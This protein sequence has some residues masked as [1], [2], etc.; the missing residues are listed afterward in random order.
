VSAD[1]T[2]G[3]GGPF[4]VVTAATISAITPASGA[5]GT[6]VTI[7]G[8]GFGASQGTSTVSFNGVAASVTNWSDTSI[9]VSV[10]SGATTGNVVVTVA[11]VSSKP[12]NFVVAG[13]LPTGSLNTARN[14]Q[15]ATLLDNGMVLI[16][17]GFDGNF[18]VL[19]NT[20]LYDPSSGKFS[21]TGSLTTPRI[22][23]TATL[24]NNGMVLMAGGLDG[25]FNTLSST[26]LYD[27]AERLFSPAGSLNTAR[28]S[29]LAVTLKNGM[30]LIVGGLDSNFN[31]LSSAELYDPGSGSFTTVAG[32]LGTARSQ[33][34]ATLLNDGTVLI[35]GGFDGNNNP[36]ASA[37]LYDPATGTFR[38][39]GT[40]NNARGAHTATL[41][42]NGL[43]LIAGGNDSNSNPIASAELYDPVA[44]SFS[45]TGSPLVPRAANTATLLNNGM[46]LIAGG[47][48]SNFNTI[49]SA[50][51]YDPAT[52][53]FT[54]TP[55]LN[56]GR[57]SP[58]A[59]LLNTGAVLIAG[60]TDSNFNRVPA[61]E[62]YQPGSLTPPGL[63]SIT[64]SPAALS[65]PAATS[66]SFTATGVFN[67]NSTQVLASVTW[68]SSDNTVATLTNDP[69][70]PG[71]AF[72]VAA[73]TATVSACAGSICGSA[74]LT[75][76]SSALTSLTITPA[77]ATLT[78]V[79]SVQLIATGTFADGGTE[80]ITSSVVW[81]TASPQTATIN[82]NGV[83]SGS[84]PG[85]T[86]VTASL[87]GVS[88]TAALTVIPAIT[89]GPQ[90]PSLALG[91]R[92][93]LSATL[94]FPDG[95]TRDATSSATWTSSNPGVAIV[96]QQGLLISRGQGSAVI[97]V[98]SGTTTA[99]ATVVI[100]SPVFVVAAINPQA[101]Q[102]PPGT[103][104]QLTVTGIYSDGSRQDLTASAVWSSA[105]STIAT[106]SSSGVLTA[107]NSGTVNIFA[108]VNGVMLS[109]IAT[110]TTPGPPTIT[111]TISPAP[112][113]NGWNNSNV[114][115]V[116]TCTPGGAVIVSCPAAQLISSEG[117][118]QVVSGTV[119][120][121]AGNSATASVS[122]NLDKT[123]PVLTVSAPVDGNNFTDTTIAATGT[124]S[125]ALSGIITL[126]CNGTPVTFTAPDFSCNI[127]L[128]PGV[129]LVVVRAGDM[130]GNMTLIKMHV[131]LTAP[132]PAPAS[133]HISPAVANLVL[134]DTQ[135]YTVM[136]EQ[137]RVRNDATWT[138]SDPTL[139]EISSDSSP[140]LTALAIGQ[141]ALTATVQGI[142]AQ[143]L[144]NISGVALSP[145]M[146]RWSDPPLTR[147]TGEHV[148][149]AVPAPGTPDLYA[150]ENGPCLD[151]FCNTLN[152][153]I[154]AYSAD[155]T[156]LWQRS[157]P[158][159][160]ASLSPSFWTAPDRFGGIV[161]QYAPDS[162][163]QSQIIDL[164]GQTGATVWQDNFRS[165]GGATNLAVRPNGDIV[166]A[167]TVPTQPFDG[168]S[169]QELF[170][171]DGNSGQR[172]SIPLQQQTQTTFFNG[173]SSQQQRL[174]LGPIT[175]D[176]DGTIYV[177]YSGLNQQTSVFI[178]GGLQ[179]NEDYR[180]Q[181]VTVAPDNSE[182]E[183][184]LQSGF[185]FR[186]AF[187]DAT[188]SVMI[189]G[190]AIPDG[191]GG[192]LA[193]WSQGPPV[194]N[195]DV[196][197]PYMV[198][199]IT[200]GGGTTYELPSLA[201]TLLGNQFSSV[202]PGFQFL[203]P[204][205]NESGTAFAAS[206]HTTAFDII[207][208]QEAW[209]TAGAGVGGSGSP[210]LIA[211]GD[212]GV[213]AGGPTFDSQGKLGA[214]L[215]SGF[216]DATPMAADLWTGI[217]AFTLGPAV[218]TGPLNSTDFAA[219]AFSISSGE[220][221]P[222]NASRDV[223]KVSSDFTLTESTKNGGIIRVFASAQVG[224]SFVDKGADVFV[225]NKSNP[226]LPAGVFGMDG[227]LSNHAV[228]SQEN[229]N[230]ARP[231]GVPDS[232]IALG[233]VIAHEFGHYLL[234]CI[235]FPDPWSPAAVYQNM[236]AVTFNGK[237]YVS[238]VNFN[239]N[240]QPDLHPDLWTIN[241]V[242]AT[243][244]NCGRDG[245]MAP[246]KLHDIDLLFKVDFGIGN[247][248]TRDQAIAIRK[249][250]RK[251]HATH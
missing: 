16:A 244:S 122:V 169:H 103:S 206:G 154:V 8:S 44:G 127:S 75:V 55:D 54:A 85:N 57:T 79:S 249:K 29:S 151:R 183:Q 203:R 199:H 83:A 82:A 101:A 163:L 71:Q 32:A 50:E 231:A 205:I 238:S 247:V 12:V 141:P 128:T 213:I 137:G 216:I 78:T 160:N 161:I 246:G 73:G 176:A 132:L 208:G 42:N 191:Q 24:L 111:A 219:S 242:P 143:T 17:G 13:F 135:Q 3:Y 96:N 52:G 229:L 100:T 214:E 6:Q 251:L 210:L 243:I 194:I 175:S 41:L 227:S 201:V 136:D 187:G 167:I 172:T 196:T 87:G 106:V 221:A 198:T 97:T 118:N 112:N 15:T 107:A 233:V 138:I 225:T 159:Q 91:L 245:I 74:P 157:L 145:G 26:E 14:N 89:I 130:A 23:H 84:T 70:N 155:G 38:A 33:P 123:P 224:V 63:A 37:E 28:N 171:L 240:H 47:F 60:G 193:L 5:I 48:D 148:F 152:K 212:G 11:G 215:P 234:N 158:Q 232:N 30:V 18:S 121:S 189:V 190:P 226:P 125:D 76:N 21:V 250:L 98:T 220:T 68:S 20:E 105:D 147:A 99:S 27:P 150:V 117:A 31:L 81:S 22:S 7:T 56:T 119:T 153:L 165:D 139:A 188:G 144:V 184:T 49:A 1:G 182:T 45:V 90:N 69:S 140:Q 204:V 94:N 58:T 67:D 131:T 211:R 120:D 217:N 61:A 164:D 124:L 162:S 19:S 64:L 36:L 168:T 174:G 66:R 88:A 223:L 109:G 237:I 236:Q 39:M 92:Q 129:N 209:T 40:L 218:F 46:V 35:V 25:S 51:L 239:Q 177:E 93:Q 178:N 116:F 228:V 146:E 179:S 202:N 34:T 230:A 186:P 59:T 86:S 185:I 2:T 195:Q 166:L 43:V 115:V 197:E 222:T 142:S 102:L 235:H 62:L 65:L 170:V 156:Q 9:S 77:T 114:T 192:I 108:A 133:L 181:L 248:F 4:F 134:G 241:N 10:P 104:R 72:A 53:I 207:S 180:L 95:S 126:T 80:D 173:V 149:Q 200:P 110:V 113:E